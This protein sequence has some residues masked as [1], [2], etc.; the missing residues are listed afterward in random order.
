MKNSKKRINP[1]TK[2]VKKS[3]VI[4]LKA[5]KKLKGGIIDG[6]IIDGR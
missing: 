3:Q 2:Q 4:S 1:I 5:K 6:D